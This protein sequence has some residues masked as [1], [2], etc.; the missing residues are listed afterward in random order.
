MTRGLDGATAMRGAAQDF[1]MSI[2]EVLKGLDG[3]RHV[4]VNT[5]ENLANSAMAFTRFT[6]NLASTSRNDGPFNQF[7]LIGTDFI[8]SMGNSQ[9]C[10]SN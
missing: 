6:A 7:G 3:M 9:L 10:F 8:K 4:F 2:P 1:G 5:E